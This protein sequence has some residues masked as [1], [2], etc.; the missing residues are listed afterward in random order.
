MQKKIKLSI[1]LRIV[2]LKTS[3]LYP[4]KNFMKSFTPVFKVQSLS[5]KKDIGLLEVFGTKILTGDGKDLCYIKNSTKAFCPIEID[6]NR[7]KMIEYR[8]SI[9]PY[10]FML[11]RNG[12]KDECGK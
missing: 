2:S 3:I 6:K 11:Y 8:N 10:G 4:L 5:S 9:N 1:K 7:K 12:Y